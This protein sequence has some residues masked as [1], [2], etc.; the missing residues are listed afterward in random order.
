MQTFT[1]TQRFTQTPDVVLAKYTDPDFLQRKYVELGRQDIEVLEQRVENGRARLRIAYS[2]KA[3]TDVPDFAKR[4]MPERTHV[5]QTVGWD[6]ERKVGRIQVEP[7]GAP[8]KVQG[9]LRMEARDGGALNTIHWTV[10]C[11]VPLIGGKLEKLLMEG[12]RQK[13][14]KDQAVSQ[15]LLSA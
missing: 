8:V 13:A 4:F 15:T 12:I 5:V 1:D 3:E 11:A 14:A 10:S 9:E 2:D 7:K 6:L